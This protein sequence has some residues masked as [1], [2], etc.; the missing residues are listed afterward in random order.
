MAVLSLT[1]KNR[2]IAHYT[3]R[4]LALMNGTLIS[5]GAGRPA[6]AKEGNFIEIQENLLGLGINNREDE[7]TQAAAI[8]GAVLGRIVEVQAPPNDNGA[9]RKLAALIADASDVRHVIA[10]VDVSLDI[11][12]LK[13]QDLTVPIG[14]RR[15]GGGNRFVATCDATWHQ[16]IT[17]AHMA[18]WANLEINMEEGEQRFHGQIVAVMNVHYEGYCLLSGDQKYVLFHCY[19][20]N[21]SPLLGERG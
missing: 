4:R 8:L 10:G 18:A 14:K 19:P 13:H 3:P 15:K 12:Q 1:N 7:V 17:M 9:A 5:T 2:I 21:L 20:S 6:M 16:T 11:D